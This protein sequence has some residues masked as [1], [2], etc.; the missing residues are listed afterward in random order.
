MATL[1]NVELETLISDLNFL[2]E[3]SLLGS[4][5]QNSRPKAITVVSG[6]ESMFGRASYTIKP[7]EN[8]ECLKVESMILMTAPLSSL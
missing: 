5:S 4:L 6:D 8:L 7:F 3:V 1:V 2:G